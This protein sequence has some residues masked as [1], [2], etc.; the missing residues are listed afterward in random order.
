MKQ[1]NIP[2][3][4]PCDAAQLIPHEPPM[5]L[6]KRLIEKDDDAEGGSTSIVEAEVPLSG[7]FI[8]KGQLMPEYYIEVIAQAIAASDGYPQL[9]EKKPTT[10]LLTGIDGFSWPAD[11]KP[12]EI[13]HITLRKTFE[14]GSAFIFTGS[15][16][17]G[18]KQ[19]A[20][21]QLKI[22]KLGE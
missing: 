22:W 18:S 5:L 17:S 6:V 7:P 3:S 10:G 19:I 4:L 21:G 11:A 12:G 1:T 14:F 15:I 13:I 2:H 9:E 8:C 16:T 20:E